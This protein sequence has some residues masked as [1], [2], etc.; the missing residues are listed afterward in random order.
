MIL[1]LIAVSHPDSTQNPAGMN[2]N[3]P[4][5]VRNERCPRY[6]APRAHS[7]SPIGWERAGVRVCFPAHRL[8]IADPK[9]PKDQC[10]IRTSEALGV[11][12]SFLCLFWRFSF[13]HSLTHSPCAFAIC[14][15]AICHF[16][17]VR[18]RPISSDPRARI[19]LAKPTH[20]HDHNLM[21]SRRATHVPAFL[22][23]Q[24]PY[25]L[26]LGINSQFLGQYQLSRN[27]FL[28]IK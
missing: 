11:R 28:V 16:L 8:A 7:P 15:V 25:D 2:E 10:T 14:H 22:P 9:L 13:H 21:D 5:P 24:R 18:F 19:T 1:I 6:S 20:R 23:G 17:N 4:G 12:L 3:S 26:K 27:R